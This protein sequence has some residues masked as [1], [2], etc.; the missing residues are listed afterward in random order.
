MFGWLRKLLR[1]KQTVR[2]VR[3]RYDAAQTNDDNAR[4]WAAADALS[5][6]SANSAA[7]RAVLR[8]RARYE[9]TNNGIAA[10][11]VSTL[12][13]DVIGTGPRLQ[14]MAKR[15]LTRPL[16]RTFARWADEI[17]LADK[18]RTMRR[19][20]AVD[21][22]CFGVLTNNPR[23]MSPIQLDLRTCEADRVANSWMESL[24]NTGGW[25]DGIQYD[26]FGNPTRYRILNAHP[27][28]VTQFSTDPMGT[29][30]YDAASV[31]HDY[32]S[33]RPGQL[34]GVPEMV[35]TLGLFAEMRRY[36]AAVLA[37]AE[38]AA[39]FAW[40]MK[41]TGVSSTVAGSDPFSTIDIERRMGQVLPEG[42][43]I[44][45]LKAEQPT[46]TLGMFVNLLV[47]IAARPFNMPLNVALCN[48][49]GYNY[50]SGRMDHQVYQRAIGIDREQYARRVLDR[51][52]YAWLNEAALVPGLI[53]D[54][55]GPFNQWDW[56]W[57]WDG[58]AHVDP[59]KEATAQATRL[60]NHTTTLQAEYAAEGEDWEEALTQRG[61]EVARM[62]ALDLPIATAPVVLQDASNQ[63][64]GQNATAN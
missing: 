62:K 25:I 32:K 7:I 50:A 59:S 42:W 55:L 39:D 38:T 31:L 61:I 26:G 60:A 41:A 29:T 33:E 34:R 30:E 45:Q 18:L 19:T 44:A 58:F 47:N 36:T 8:K 3:G 21:G 24:T 51:I 40:F 11:I 56:A 12:T 27:G 57:H 28:D 5:A 52:L 35:S 14:I 20:R 48:S 6:A 4:H 64:G 23:L 43:D 15:E 16:E 54:G 49:S 1:S 17:D 37:A 22:E 53:P 13:N 46:T 63:D 10:G 9:C 2:M